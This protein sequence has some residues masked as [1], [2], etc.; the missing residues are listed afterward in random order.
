MVRKLDD[1][2]LRITL[3]CCSCQQTIGHTERQWFVLYINYE[4]EWFSMSMPLYRFGISVLCLLAIPSCASKSFEKVSLRIAAFNVSMESTNY[5]EADPNK[6]ALIAR[7]GD[8]PQVKNIAQI[9]QT[10]RPDIILLKEFDFID[11]DNETVKAFI[12]NYLHVAQNNAEAIDY[13]YMLTAEVNTGQLFPVD[14]NGDQ[15][16]RLPEDAFGW[17]RY[18]GHY[19]MV[20][21]SRFPIVYSEVKTFQRFLWKD[22]PGARLPKTEQGEPYYNSDQLEYFRLSSKSHWD[23]PVNIG[24]THVHILASHPTPPVF[25]GPEDRNGLRNFDEI[26][27]I[28]D[29]IDGAD[30]I[31]DDSGRPGSEGI[32]DAFV[33]LGDLNAADNGGDGV[34][35]AIEQ[36]T[37]HNRILDRVPISNGAAEMW[38][39]ETEKF[40]ATH[41]SGL[42]LDYVLPSTDFMIEGAGVFWPAVSEIGAQLMSD[43]ATSS[44]HRLVWV[45]IKI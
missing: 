26:R 2:Q 7:T 6:L 5:G 21:L 1:H 43:R 8:H 4:Y 16:V 13:P 44:D 11:D 14:L 40:R 18:P 38:A 35:G 12:S 39:S 28:K 42:R 23:V 25:D 27:L 3:F 15:Y 24:G 45:D 30:Y 32:S 9:I 36:L 31:Y 10:V 41:T 20:L 37:K 34:R 33:V 22:M 29:Y 17:G 19:G